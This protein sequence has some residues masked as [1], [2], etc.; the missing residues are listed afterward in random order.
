MGGNFAPGYS[1]GTVLEVFDS[2]DTR[3]EYVLGVSPRQKVF[4]L[5]FELPIPAQAVK[6]RVKGAATGAFQLGTWDATKPE[7]TPLD[8]A[9][10]R[11]GA[12]CPSHLRWTGIPFTGEEEVVV[13]ASPVTFA[14][15]HVRLPYICMWDS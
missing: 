12:T 4:S 10:H 2:G 3:M 14:A 15:S 8:P 11:L 9:R 1:S 13:Y 6:L 7:F 5:P